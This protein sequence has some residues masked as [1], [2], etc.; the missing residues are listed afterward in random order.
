MNLQ[1]FKEK[2]GITLIALVVTI[3][4]LLILAGISIQMLTGNSGILMQTQNA[5]DNTRGGDVQE[6]VNLAVSENAIAE[7]TSGTKKTRDGVIGELYRDKK[8][9]N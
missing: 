2:R 5:K 6:Q 1:R 9:P 3:I 4:V 7:Y 8:L